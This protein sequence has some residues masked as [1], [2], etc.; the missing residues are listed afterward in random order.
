MLNF[1]ELRQ[2]LRQGCL[3]RP[4][5]NLLSRNV[6]TLEISTYQTTY[7]GKKRAKQI[8]LRDSDLISVGYSMLHHCQKVLSEQRVLLF[9]AEAC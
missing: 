5:S 4:R 1:P 7:G 3:H 9:L 2:G 6:G 8:G